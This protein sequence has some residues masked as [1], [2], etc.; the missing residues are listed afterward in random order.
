M[1]LLI[2]RCKK[3]G[4]GLGADELYREFR[5]HLNRGINQIV[6]EKDL[7][8]VVALLQKAFIQRSTGDPLI[9][10]QQ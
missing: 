3:D 2:E 7:K 9:E 8:S 6:L 4:V 1:A 5:H 10:E